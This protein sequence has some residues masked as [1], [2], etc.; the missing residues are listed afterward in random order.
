MARGSRAQWRILEESSPRVFVLAVGFVIVG[1]AFQAARGR[2]GWFEHAGAVIFMLGVLAL[3]AG[4]LGLYPRHRARAPVLTRMSSVA[5]AMGAVA[6][7]VAGTWGVTAL[8]LSAFGV[9]VAAWPPNPVFVVLYLGVVL[10]LVGFGTAVLRAGLLSRRIGILLVLG[11]VIA[12]APVLL[13]ILPALPVRDAWVVASLLVVWAGTIL[14]VGFL[15]SRNVHY[16]A[17][18]FI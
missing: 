15:L 1:V 18:G 10:G 8:A 16:G 5:V 7:L 14:A 6:A 3:S 11:G 13:G 12:G 2:V 17:L 4:L 9:P